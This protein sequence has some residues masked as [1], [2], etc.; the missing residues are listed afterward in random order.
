VIFWLVNRHADEA[1]TLD[2]AMA[3]F[4]RKALVEHVSITHPD[5]QATNTAKHPNRVQPA[6]GKGVSVKD[7]AVR[8]KLPPRSWQMLR[9]AV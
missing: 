7:G 5:L 2:L 9:I 4:T 3:G 6:K 8:G 1:L